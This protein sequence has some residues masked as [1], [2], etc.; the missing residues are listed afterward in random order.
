LKTRSEYWQKYLIG[1]RKGPWP[2]VNVTAESQTDIPPCIR[3]RHRSTGYPSTNLPMKVFFSD[4]PQNRNLIETSKKFT[5]LE[6]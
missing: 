4:A 2:T 5:H 3:E 6:Y 1:M